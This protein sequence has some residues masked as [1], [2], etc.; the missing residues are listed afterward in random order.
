MK[1]TEEMYDTVTSV[2]ADFIIFVQ[3]IKCFVIV[4][5]KQIIKSLN[6]IE[7]QAGLFCT[8]V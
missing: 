5:D 8:N 3:W 2:H 1:D 6:K 4:A 7:E